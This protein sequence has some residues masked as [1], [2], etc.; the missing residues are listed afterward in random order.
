[1]HGLFLNT[2]IDSRKNM[3]QISKLLTIVIK[4]NQI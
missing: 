4:S 3:D 2:I 1:M